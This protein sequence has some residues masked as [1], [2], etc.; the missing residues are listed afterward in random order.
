VK[1]KI[2]FIIFILLIGGKSYAKE[3]KCSKGLILFGEYPDTVSLKIEDSNKIIIDKI[4]FKFE[5][6][7]VYDE[8]TKETLIT[9]QG[10]KNIGTKIYTFVYEETRKILSYALVDTK[11]KQNNFILLYTC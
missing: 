6:V 10:D 2:L 8:L 3:I 11:N 1:I 7:S 4:L 9:I 5:K